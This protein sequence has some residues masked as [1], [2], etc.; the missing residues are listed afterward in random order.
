MIRTVIFDFDGTIADT[1]P[2][3]PEMLQIL[4]KLT[5]ELGVREIT[6]ADIIRFREQS[7]HTILQELHIPLFK[8]PFLV[9]RVKTALQKNLNASTPIPHMKKTL[10]NIKKA[11]YAMSIVT[12]SNKTDVENF[13]KRNR[14]EIFDVL[15]TGI[16]LFGKD[17]LINSLMQKYQLKPKEVVYI[18]DEIRD[19]EAA[20][21]AHIKVI[22]VSWGFNAKKGL[23]KNNPDFLIDKPQELLNT[24]Q[25]C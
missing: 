19:I 24:I 2:S 12:S 10:L 8:V 9:T 18:G 23:Q 11:G 6:K 1:I 21:K 16:T 7:I 20:K 17:R 14:L 13:L 25:A 22:A 5:K 3:Y 4:S 15:Y